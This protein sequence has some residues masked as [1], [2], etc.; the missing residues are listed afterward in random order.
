MVFRAKHLHEA[1]DQF[2]KVGGPTLYMSC[3]NSLFNWTFYFSY[4]KMEPNGK[5]G[6]KGGT[7]YFS[8][9]KWG[10]NVSKGDRFFQ[11]ILFSPGPFPPEIFNLV[12]GDNFGGTNSYV[13]VPIYCY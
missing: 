9:K 2:G 11:K 3:K 10:P 7:I 12:E 1:G 5:K 13:T 6:G 4:T 8:C